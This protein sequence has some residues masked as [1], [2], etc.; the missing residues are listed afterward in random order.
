MAADWLAEIAAEMSIECLPESYQGIAQIIG[1]AATLQLSEY[2]GGSR[3]YFRKIDGL[4][5]D[6]RDD[7]I[8]KEFNGGNHLELARRYRL[9]E[10][11]IRDILARKRPTQCGLFENKEE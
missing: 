2:L 10:T 9:T 5:M 7:R 11:R 3:F 6:K 4:L 1:I 8:R